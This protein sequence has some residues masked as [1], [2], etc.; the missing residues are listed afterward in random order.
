MK[1]ERERHAL[2]QKPGSDYPG[3]G[4]TG[5]KVKKSQGKM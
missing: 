2:G 1:E 3:V 4:H 5:K